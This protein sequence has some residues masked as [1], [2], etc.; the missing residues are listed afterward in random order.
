MS[1]LSS[2]TPAQIAA[3]ASALSSTPTPT[4][5]PTPGGTPT[6]TPTPSSGAA[7]YSANCAGC[8]GAL[9][10]SSVKGSSASEIQNAI[11]SVSKMSGFKGVFTS[12]QIQSIAS[13]LAGG[14]AK[15]D[16]TEPSA[17]PMMFAKEAGDKTRVAEGILRKRPSVLEIT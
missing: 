12:S 5:T 9:A 2:L 17:Q 14:G 13:A 10:S 8:H 4:P 1:G 3:I 7:L 15:N 16:A 6:P 11:N